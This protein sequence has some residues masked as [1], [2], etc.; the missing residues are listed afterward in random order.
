LTDPRWSFDVGELVKEIEKIVPKQQSKIVTWLWGK[1][2]FYLSE[3]KLLYLSNNASHWKRGTVIVLAVLFG[4]GLGL[5]LGKK[6]IYPVVSQPIGFATEPNDGIYNATPIRFGSSMK[7]KLTERDP[8]DWYVFKTP[9]DI[10]DE[11]LVIFRYIDGNVYG[12][13]IQVYDSDENIISQ[14]DLWFAENKSLDIKANKDTIY[15]IK[16]HGSNFNYEL[17]I[18]NKSADAAR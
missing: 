1:L 15:Y 2:S 16:I 6:D 10:G 12:S 17:A 8:T 11:F 14:A 7:G 5:I 4:I 18:R 13:K 9:D 3:L